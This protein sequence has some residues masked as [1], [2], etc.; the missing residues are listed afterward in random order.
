MII[1]ENQ[2]LY[3]CSYCKK[4]LL[5][6]RGCRLHETKYCSNPDSEYQQGIGRWKAECPHERTELMWSY[7]PGEAVKEPSHT[8]CVRC[9]THV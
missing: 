5:T 3:Q 4:R 2:K 7:I 8:E 9:G 6:K 1:L